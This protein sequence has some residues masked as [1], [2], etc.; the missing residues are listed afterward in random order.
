MVL[1]PAGGVSNPRSISW[2]TTT[3]AGVFPSGVGMRSGSR[4]MP[5]S[6]PLPRMAVM[7]G[8]FHE[9]MVSRMRTS[10]R[11]AFCASSF[12][13][14][15]RSTASEAAQTSGLP[16]YVEPCEPG[17][18]SEENAVPSS[19]MARSLSQNA[20]IGTPPPMP[21]AHE[22]PSGLISGAIMRQAIESPQRPK[23]AWTSSKNKSRSC[24]LQTAA[25]ARR[26]SGVAMF[27]PP[28]PWI[29]SSRIAAVSG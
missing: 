28:S 4:P 2:F 17:P 22:M 18:M 16:P 5:S 20:P 29:G 14:I 8:S 21:L 15:S 3:S 26:N 6:N 9:V 19:S 7:T 27:T 1:G 23:P 13:R 25:M 11:M 12:S 24:F 10:M